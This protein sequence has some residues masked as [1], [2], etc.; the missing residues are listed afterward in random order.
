MYA[1]EAT[2]WWFWGKRHLMR[3][4]IRKRLAA[5][6]L[7]ILDVGCGAGAN[8]LELSG[9]GQVTAMDRS[10]DALGFVRSR[11]VAEVVAGDA[12]RLPF[13]DR[14]FDLVTAY[15]VVEHLDD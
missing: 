6:G 12:T 15:D 5:P 1:L 8:A 14:S 10:L 9:Y 4:L 2:H 11:G 7:R 13:A 3:R